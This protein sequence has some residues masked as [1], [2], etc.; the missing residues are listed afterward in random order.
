LARVFRPQAGASALKVR[1][2][3]GN[4]SVALVTMEDEQ[5]LRHRFLEA[6]AWGQAAS[7]QG[8]NG[9]LQTLPRGCYL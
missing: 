3:W 4:D 7:Q 1:D 5:D 8:V 6:P 2:R 9:G